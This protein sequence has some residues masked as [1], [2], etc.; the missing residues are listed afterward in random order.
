LGAVGEQALAFVGEV[1][2]PVHPYDEL[3]AECLL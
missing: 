3:D 2:A 1:D